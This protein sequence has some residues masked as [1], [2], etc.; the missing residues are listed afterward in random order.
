MFILNIK[1]ILNKKVLPIPLFVIL[2]FPTSFIY[3]QKKDMNTTSIILT[4]TLISIATLY[5][6][7]LLSDKLPDI[8][9]RFDRKP[10]NCRP[11]LTFH[12]TW[13]TSGIFA[14]VFHTWQLIAGGILIAF[15]LFGILKFINNK[16]ITE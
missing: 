2:S 11:C 6:G 14:L 3:I 13:L 8:D 1:Q 16:K 5:W 4:L 7:A 15:I 12:L 9:N 10:F